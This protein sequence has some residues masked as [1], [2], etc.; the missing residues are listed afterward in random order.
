MQTSKFAK[1]RVLKTFSLFGLTAEEVYAKKAEGYNPMDC[2]ENNEELRNVID[3]IA[4]GYFSYG[5]KKLF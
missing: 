5:D 4:N 1:K 3:R 2:Y